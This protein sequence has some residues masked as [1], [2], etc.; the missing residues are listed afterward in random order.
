MSKTAAMIAALLGSAH[1]VSAA[2]APT[3]A[4]AIPFAASKCGIVITQACLA[5]IKTAKG[6]LQHGSYRSH[7]DAFGH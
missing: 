2:F 3:F 1:G 5:S 4:P 6:M 7:A